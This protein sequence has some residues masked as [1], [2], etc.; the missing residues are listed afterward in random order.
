[1]RS[2]DR[3]RSYIGTPPAQRF[4]AR[5]TV[6]PVTGCHRWFGALDTCGYGRLHVD[7]RLVQAHRY[8]LTLAGV[9][10]L[11]NRECAHRCGNRACVNVAHIEQV[12]RSANR[13]RAA[14]RR[15]RYGQ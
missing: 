11:P 13:A 5:F 12:P 10:L 14:H 8:A 15:R 1:M 4:R 3:A 6:D 9:E 7:G 2:T